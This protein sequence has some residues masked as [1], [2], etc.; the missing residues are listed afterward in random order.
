MTQYQQI[1][2][3]K[4]WFWLMLAIFIAL[5]LFFFFKL[6]LGVIEPGGMPNHF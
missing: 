3:E 4:F 2:G 1:S 6:H 5:Y